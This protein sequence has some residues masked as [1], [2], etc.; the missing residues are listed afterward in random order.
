MHLCICMVHLTPS[1]ISVQNNGY[2]PSDEQKGHTNLLELKAC[3]FSIRTF[4]KHMSNIHGRAYTDNMT[5]CAYI[6][7]Y[8]GKYDNLDTIARRH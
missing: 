6:N 7:K 8:G 2:W 3:Q 1:I 4:C 5:I